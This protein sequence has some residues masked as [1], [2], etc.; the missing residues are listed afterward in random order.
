MSLWQLKMGDAAHV[1]RRK[2]ALTCAVLSYL[3]LL[4]LVIITF[5]PQKKTVTIL[6]PVSDRPAIV[7]WSGRRS[8]GA[9]TSP[10]LRGAGRLGR[11]GRHARGEEHAASAKVNRTKAAKEMTV[12]KNIV[13]KPPEKKVEKI[14]EKNKLKKSCKKDDKHVVVTGKIASKKIEQRDTDKP[15]VL[16]KTVKKPKIKKVVEAQVKEEE[17]LPDIHQKEAVVPT[18][19]AASDVVEIG[20]GNEEAPSDGVENLDGVNAD[21]GANGE[22]SRDEYALMCAVGRA[23]RPPRG[24][25]SGLQARLVVAVSA[26]GRADRVDIAES[27]HVPAYDIAA[28]ASLYRAEYPPVFWGKNLAVVFGQTRK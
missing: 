27:S 22:V 14:L 21:E 19:P 8:G 9:P 12:K 25:K 24:L 20:I 7:R 13:S 5:M 26:Q 28:R 10:R 15:V 18:V 4:V 23:W 17:T 11:R 2:K 6:V 16:E 3:L 1:E